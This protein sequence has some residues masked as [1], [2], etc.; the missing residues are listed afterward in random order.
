[1]LLLVAVLLLST[2]EGQSVNSFAGPFDLELQRVEA[3]P[4]AISGL[5]L[6]NITRGLTQDKKYPTRFYAAGVINHSFNIMPSV[7]VIVRVSSWNRGRW[8]ENVY[9][10]TVPRACEEF[11]A[12]AEDPAS[13]RLLRSALGPDFSVTC[14][15]PAAT[16]VKNLR[17]AGTLIVDMLNFLD[18]NWA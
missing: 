10:H 4:S 9:H 13:K 12:R 3:C 7:A 8:K 1:M 6:Y 16:C 15:F 18:N 11:K 2:V 17:F 5:N 14:P